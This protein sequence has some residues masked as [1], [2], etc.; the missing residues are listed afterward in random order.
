MR[1]RSRPISR[2][3]WL[4]S[5]ASGALTPRADAQN[6]VSPLQEIPGRVTP[7]ARFFVRNHFA[8]PELSIES[9]TLTIEGR[10]ARRTRLGFSDLLEAPPAKLEAVLECAGNPASG[11]A[12][13]NGIWEGVRLAWMIDQARPDSSATHILLEG[14]DSGSL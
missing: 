6:V 11:P 13:S 3:A 1:F 4:A 14:A 8:E 5:L 10:C 2:R 12:V 9:W 7:A